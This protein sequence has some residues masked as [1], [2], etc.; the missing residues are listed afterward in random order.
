MPHYLVQATIG[1]LVS[2][3]QYDFVNGPLIVRLPCSISVL[4]GG[5][6]RCPIT[7]NL[8]YGLVGAE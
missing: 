2:A 6:S 4:I 8:L 5:V 3:G 1:A 7:T